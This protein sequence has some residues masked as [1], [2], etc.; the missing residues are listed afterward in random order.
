MTRPSRL[1]LTA[2]LLMP[3]VTTFAVQIDSEIAA[4]LLS[5]KRIYVDEFGDDKVAKVLQSMVVNA[6]VDSKKFIVTENKEKADAV[7]K[8]SALQRTSQEF[9]STSEGTSVG[10]IAGAISGGTGIVAGGG[11]GIADSSTSTETIDQAALAVRLVASDGDT[12]WSTTQ[13]SKGAKYKGAQ[14]DVADK[15]VKQ[16]LRDREKLERTIA[17]GRMP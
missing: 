5:V 1:F 15:I 3:V 6:L 4:K 16:L 2:L 10:S 7:L 11:V 14:A 17:P 8:G 9:R 13:E 12:I